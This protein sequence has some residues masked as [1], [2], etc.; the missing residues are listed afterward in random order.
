MTVADTAKSLLG[1]LL[2]PIHAG[3]DKLLALSRELTPARDLIVHS[4]AFELG[5]TIPHR[6]LG[7]DLG[8]NISPPLEWSHVPAHT[9]DLVLVC[10]DPDAPALQPFVH[11]VLRIPPT[12]TKL[13]EG[14]PPGARSFSEFPGLEQGLNSANTRGY[15]GPLPPPGHGVHHYYFQLFALDQP[16]T[17]PDSHD[18]KAL[19]AAMTGHVLAQGHHIGIHERA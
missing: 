6:H 15:H 3:E 1:K 18:H 13:P 19:V 10:E 12:A 11:W 7:P 16:I 8:G 9:A 14:I 4:P 2:R 17:L 5:A